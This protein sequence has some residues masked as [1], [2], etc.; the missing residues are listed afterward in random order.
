MGL[1]GS[2]AISNGKS[3]VI[4]P[5]LDT[6]SKCG[7]VVLAVIGAVGGAF[8]CFGA[9]NFFGP[10]G[11]LNFIAT[12]TGGGVAILIAAGGITY[13]V[14][15]N[16]KPKSDT[17]ASGAHSQ[18]HHAA[19]SSG[20]AHVFSSPDMSRLKPLSDLALKTVNWAEGQIKSDTVPALLPGLYQPIDRY[21]AKLVTLYQSAEKEFFEALKNYTN[22]PWH[23]NNAI[24]IIKQEGRKAPPG[25]PWSDPSVTAEIERRVAELDDWNASEDPW[26]KLSVQIT[27][28]RMIKFGFA[29]SLRTLD[30]THL[31]TRLGATKSR[32]SAEWLCSKD[33]YMSMT[34]FHLSVAY[35][36]MRTRAVCTD[37]DAN[38]LDALP[39]QYAPKCFLKLLK[40]EGHPLNEC[41]ALYNE[42]SDRVRQLTTEADLMAADG[43]DRYVRATKKDNGQADFDTPIMIPN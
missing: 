36:W 12:V 41:F 38:R 13:I 40:Q 27:A 25:N 8:I 11:S 30:D 19:K 20:A 18:Q 5:P 35:T 6:K 15:K 1:T 37:A 42:F 28:T 32:S 10:S 22:D 4:L 2:K 21:I 14:V 43:S 3:Q 9:I 17:G 33:G 23:S 26:V 34:F 29:I 16:R 24:T 7:I 39:L 31:Y